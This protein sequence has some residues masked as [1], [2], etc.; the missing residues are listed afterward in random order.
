MAGYRVPIRSL[1]SQ[2]QI[3]GGAYFKAI[4]LYNSSDLPVI[5]YRSTINFADGFKPI[6]FVDGF[7]RE[8]GI[9]ETEVFVNKRNTLLRNSEKRYH[10]YFNLKN[11]F[12]WYF[13]IL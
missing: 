12:C 6:N 4:I 8:K 10:A 1:T 11:T 5:W 3:D 2:I 9:R 13:M 7:Q